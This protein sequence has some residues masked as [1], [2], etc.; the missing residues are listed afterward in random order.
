MKKKGWIKL[1][2][3]GKQREN[4]HENILKVG[5][6]KKKKDYKNKLRNYLEN[7]TG[8]SL[9]RQYIKAT[10]YKNHELAVVTSWHNQES[11]SRT[12]FCSSRTII[13]NKCDDIKNSTCMKQ[14][15]IQTL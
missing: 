8:K 10:E 13:A 1:L 14:P 2:H 11:N 9:Y 15:Q 6:A 5:E 12:N 7:W 3:Q 4:A